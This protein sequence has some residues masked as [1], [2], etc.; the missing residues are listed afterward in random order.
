M[1]K[2]EPYNGLKSTSVYSGCYPPPNTPQNLT[3]YKKCGKNTKVLM[4]NLCDIQI[5]CTNCYVKIIHDFF[6][7]GGCFEERVIFHHPSSF[8]HGFCSKINVLNSFKNV[9]S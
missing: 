8:I 6:W 5:T 1:T 9:V 3:L 4:Q 7:G 2:L